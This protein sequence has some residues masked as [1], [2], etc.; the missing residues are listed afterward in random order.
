MTIQDFTAI[1]LRNLPG[2]GKVFVGI[3]TVLML[4]VVFWA[5]WIFY[6]EKGKIAAG[7]V[8]PYERAE[9]QDTV[10]ASEVPPEVQAD[11][12]EIWEDTAAVLTPEWD[13]ETAGKQR[14]I[15]SADIVRIAK[16]AL[17]RDK[18]PR[19]RTA[20]EERK[21]KHNLG[22]AHTHVNGQTLL[23]FAIGFVFLFTSAKPRLKKIIFALFGLSILIHV[24][25]LTGQGFAGIY[26]DMLAVSGVV[27]LVLIVS[28]AFVIFVDLA[29]KPIEST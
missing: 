20:S 1:Q 2:Y 16:I 28:M 23:Y 6:E 27:L 11:L 9:A 26:D 3:F 12:A 24:V 13:T 10:Y 4:A 21:F 18:E 29:K 17:G 15:D 19:E 5:M 7:T 22:L 8:P 25:G 14:P